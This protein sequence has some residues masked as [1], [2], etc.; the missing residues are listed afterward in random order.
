MVTTNSVKSFIHPFI[1]PQTTVTPEGTHSTLVNTVEV[2]DEWWDLC[3]SLCKYVINNVF[4]KVL[5][6]V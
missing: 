6:V 4:D 5:K 3:I 2:G 1:P